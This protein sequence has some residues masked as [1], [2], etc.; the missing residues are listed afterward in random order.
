MQS[1]IIPYVLPYQHGY[2]IPTSSK[3]WR[4]D[5]CKE[6]AGKLKD[7]EY[8]TLR[9][10][11]NYQDIKWTN[12]TFKVTGH[13]ASSFNLALDICEGYKLQSCRDSWHCDT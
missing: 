12:N 13:L 8:Q 9:S 5:K 1:S 4:C 10:L 6:A 7:D 2:F 3:N 11:K